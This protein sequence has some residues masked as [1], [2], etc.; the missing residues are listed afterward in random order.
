ML[1][2]LATTEQYLVTWF[3]FLCQGSFA[4]E[5]LSNWKLNRT[6]SIAAPFLFPIS[7]LISYSSCVSTFPLSGWMQRNLCPVSQWKRDRCPIRWP[8][9]RQCPLVSVAL[10]SSKHVTIVTG[11]TRNNVMAD[12]LYILSLFREH[13]PWF[14]R[15]HSFCEIILIKM[16]FSRK[17]DTILALAVVSH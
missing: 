6:Q 15:M 12:R 16:K 7:S 11:N 5:I 17:V 9:V 1:Y 3:F 10:C 4:Y 14:N 2:Q 8:S 13:F